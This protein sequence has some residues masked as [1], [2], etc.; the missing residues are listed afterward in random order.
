MARVEESDGGAWEDKLG[1]SRGRMG[2]R[3]GDPETPGRGGAGGTDVEGAV[4]GGPAQGAVGQE[5]EALGRESGS[6]K[7][8]G[9]GRWSQREGGR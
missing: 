8:L 3:S 7:P 1:K 9:Q 2:W 6:R 4:H 5:V